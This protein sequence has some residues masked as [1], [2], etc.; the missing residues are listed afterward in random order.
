MGRKSSSLIVVQHHAAEGPGELARWAK[1]RGVTLHVVRFDSD[2]RPPA[3]NLPTLLLGGPY[4]VLNPPEWLQRERKWVDGLVHAEVPLFGICLGAQLLAEALGG[5]VFKLPQPETGWTVVQFDD[6]R[7]LHALQW[8]EDSFSLPP[9]SKLHA[10][11]AKCVNQY[12][13]AGETRVGLQFHPEWN[14]ESVSLLNIFFG[15]NCPVL[16]RGHTSDTRRHNAINTWFL[17]RLDRWFKHASARPVVS[18]Q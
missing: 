10:S 4:S 12:F 8:H 9:G 3:G 5:S 11:S 14:A 6:G 18:S 2:E 7:K 16:R 17:A 13:S 1:Q 15:D